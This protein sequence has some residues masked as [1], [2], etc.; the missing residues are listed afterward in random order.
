MQPTRTGSAAVL[1]WALAG[2]LMF[3]VVAVGG[4]VVRE[5]RTVTAVMPV[6]ASDTATPVG[7]AALPE[8]SISIPLLLLADGNE[9]RVGDTA[10]SIRARLGQKAE[11]GRQMVEKTA[12]GERITRF[13]EHFGARFVLVFES[14][15]GPEPRVAAIY[16]H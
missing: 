15:R 3:A 7:S 4:V 6:I 12:L 9:V 16:L 13:Y 10:A 11:I 2:A 8:R 1:E 5:F 14:L